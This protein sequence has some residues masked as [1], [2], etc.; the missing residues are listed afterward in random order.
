MYVKSQIWIACPKSYFMEIKYWRQTMRHL[1]IMKTPLGTSWRVQQTL[2]N[3]I[4]N[5]YLSSN[6]L[7]QILDE[8]GPPNNV[9]LIDTNDMYVQFFR[10]FRV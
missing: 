6:G 2:G 8:L 3:Y 4:G 9:A 1:W 10:Q 5:F 7:W